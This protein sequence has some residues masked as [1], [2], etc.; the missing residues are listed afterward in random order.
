M[1]GIYLILREFYSTQSADM[2]KQFFKKFVRHLFNLG[3][4]PSLLADILLVVQ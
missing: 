1:K 3:F 4:R 2:G